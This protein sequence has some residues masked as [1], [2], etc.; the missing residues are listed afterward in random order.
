MTLPMNTTQEIQ[1]LP[2]SSEAAAE[3][4]CS[5]SSHPEQAECDSRFLMTAPIGIYRS[6][7][8]G[9]ITFA[10]QA[11]IK[12][13]G[14]SSFDEVAALNLEEQSLTSYS[15]HLFKAR[16]ELEGEIQGLE[17]S[18]HLPDGRT[19]YVRG[20]AHAVKGG[21][22]EILYFEGTVEDIT[23]RRRAE[24]A[25]RDTENRYRALVETAEEGIWVIDALNR[26]TF[27]NRKMADLLGYS[28]QE[29]TGASLFAF[30]D[31]EG[32]AIA[33]KTLERRRHGFREQRDFKFKGKDGGDLWA[34]CATSPLLDAEGHYV[35]RV[36]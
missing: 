34:I 2:G 36:A 7:A 35:G 27:V 3:K 15:R 13:L 21:G 11:F 20:N 19:I 32:R 10:N 1:D 6:T 17:A 22:G 33:E 29:M 4:F 8:D 18:W 16:L 23:A 25:L 14:L 31:P 28:V 5:S 30:M 26:T 12:L 9:H 24:L